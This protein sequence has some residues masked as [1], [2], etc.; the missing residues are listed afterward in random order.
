MVD[1][2]LFHV[3]H[4]LYCDENIEL[5]WRDGEKLISLKEES[6]GFGGDFLTEF[7][8]IRKY[9]QERHREYSSDEFNTIVDYFKID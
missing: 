1:Q 7:G 5:C 8:W 9:S 6:D 3:L 4:L 2:S